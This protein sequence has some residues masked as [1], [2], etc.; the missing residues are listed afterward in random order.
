MKKLIVLGA[1][2]CAFALESAA[3]EIYTAEEEHYV[4][5]I[6]I[7]LVSPLQLPQWK[8]YSPWNV[9]GVRLDLLHGRSFCVWGVDV[10]ISGY[11][12]TDVYGVEATGFNL[13]RGD[14]AGIQ[15]GVV[16]NSVNGDVD[17]IQFGTVVNWNRGEFTGAQGALLN[18]DGS[19]I[20]AQFGLL[21]WDMGICYGIQAGVANVSINE[22]TGAS[23][24]FVNISPRMH[25][26][27]VGV[28]NEIEEVGE[29]LQL[30]LI[31]GAKE[32]T[33]VQVGLFNVIQNSE[34]PIMTIVNA[35]F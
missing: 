26:L 10:G 30:G 24:G 27:Q 3:K 22:Y 16:A 31:N 19:F 5:P 20:G 11:T 1:L 34:F 21:N 9:W 23:F 6:E 32:F 4:T 33:G 14:V 25:G 13:V 12:Y 35:H 18:F 29:G 15:F 17:G 28:V 2:A 8:P 7:D